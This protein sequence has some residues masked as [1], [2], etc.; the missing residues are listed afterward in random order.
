MYQEPEKSERLLKVERYVKILNWLKER[1][2]KGRN[3][4]LSDILQ[5]SPLTVR[6]DVAELARQGLVQATR[7]GVMLLQSSATFEPIYHAK[8]NEEADAKERIARHAVSQI[9][10]GD[11]I[12]LD[13]GTT[14]GAMAKHLLGRNL[15]VVTNALNVI[16]VLSNDRGIHLIAIGGMF[17]ST[18]QTFL[19]PLANRVL[20]ELRVDKSYLG[21]EGFSP[22]RGFE[23]PDGDDASFKQLA[24]DAC[25][26]GW[27]LA[28]HS[29][30]NQIRLHRFSDWNGIEGLITSQGLTDT[31][32]KQ[33]EELHLKV[34][35][36]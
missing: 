30:F 26:S 34:V 4:D 5:V 35:T 32:L 12:L 29:K 24:V 31:A 15:T 14:V 23:V 28:T 36:V 22:Q 16:N 18:S 21:T 9:R 33:F 11:T 20:K 17:R 13:G 25:E 19:G 10:D 3:S 7:G 6:R 1:E 2:G 8:L 27:V